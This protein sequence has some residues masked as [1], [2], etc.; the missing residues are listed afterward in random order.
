[1][2]DEFVT[3]TSCSTPRT[4]TAVP[5]RARNFSTPTSTSSS[6]PAR[7]AC[8]PAPRSVSELF[9]ADGP[10]TTG[11][12]EGTHRFA[13]VTPGSQLQRAPGAPSEGRPVPHPGP[14]LAPPT[15][16]GNHCRSR[17]PMMRRYLAV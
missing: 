5:P 15:G 2:T 6:P 7:T 12:F 10:V 3:W 1:M 9:L 8:T 13:D 4:D 11:F 17:L 16:A 14:A